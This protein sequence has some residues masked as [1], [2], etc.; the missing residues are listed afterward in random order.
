MPNGPKITKK[1][2]ETVSSILKRFRRECS[3]AG[4]KNELKKRR[5]HMTP[6]EIKNIDQSTEK[7]RLLKDR[8]REVKRTKQVKTQKRRG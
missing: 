2:N 1:D 6:S 7:R 5:F 3:R 4:I 8:R